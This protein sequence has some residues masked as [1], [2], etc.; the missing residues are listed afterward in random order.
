MTKLCSVINCTKDAADNLMSELS[1]GVVAFV[2]LC[3]AHY[4]QEAPLPEEFAV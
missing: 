3:Q 4:E 2:P 1:N